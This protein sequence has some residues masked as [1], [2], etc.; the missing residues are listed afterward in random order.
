VASTH[1]DEIIQH[2]SSL[3]IA[4]E[5]L[6]NSRFPD[7]KTVS[8]QTTK[9][10]STNKERLHTPARP[11]YNFSRVISTYYCGTLRSFMS[12]SSI[13]SHLKWVIGPPHVI[14]VLG[15]P[16]QL[17]IPP[18]QFP[19]SLNCSTVCQLFPGELMLSDLSS[20]HCSNFTE[21]F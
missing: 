1:T 18:P 9:N 6:L 16:P 3:N 2:T 7:C 10:G 15:V 8:R 13:L 5:D 17:S 21:P 4:N 14:I 20:N 12:I 11:C 19:T